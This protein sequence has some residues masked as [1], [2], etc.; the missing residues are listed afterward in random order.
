MQFLK[1]LFWVVIAA[2]VVI[3]SMRN[4]TPVQVNLWGGLAADVK[5]PLLLLL[6]FTAGFVPCFLAFKASCWQLRR[7]LD[8]ANRALDDMRV[9]LLRP[10][11]P[12]PGAPDP[13]DDFRDQP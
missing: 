13:A 11:D 4:W 8:A 7:K 10:A 3:F 9:Q 5:L 2:I 6:M 1:T 12:A